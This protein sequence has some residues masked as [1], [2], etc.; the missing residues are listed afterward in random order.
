[1]IVRIFR[2]IFSDGKWL[3]KEY[4]G[5][6]W[7]DD[8]DEYGNSF[9]KQ[10]VD[11]AKADEKQTADEA[12]WLLDVETY[13]DLAGGQDHICFIVEKNGRAVGYRDVIWDGN[14]RVDSKYTWVVPSQRGKRIGTMLDNA[15]YVVLGETIDVYLW[16]RENAHEFWLKKGYKD[17]WNTKQD[18]V[19]LY[20][21]KKEG[22]VAGEQKEAPSPSLSS[23]VYLK[24]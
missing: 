23:L 11:A 2:N 13:Y 7:K 4:I 17:T 22:A 10:I 24:F 12:P 1:M 3:G 16:A 18:G 19:L 9:R 15:L 6:E 20:E 8:E 21:M 14:R 5:G